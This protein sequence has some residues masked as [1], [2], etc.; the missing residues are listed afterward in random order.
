MRLKLYVAIGVITLVASLAQA[1][2]LLPENNKS[3]TAPLPNL[4]LG[5]TSQPTDSSPAKTTTAPIT[6]R[7]TA[8]AGTAPAVPSTTTP[9]L[10]PE[11]PNIDLAVPP[12]I[13]KTMQQPRSFT[14]EEI[15]SIKAQIPDNLKA[16]IPKEMGSHIPDNYKQIISDQLDDLSDRQ[17]RSQETPFAFKP[18]GIIKTEKLTPVEQ[19]KENYEQEI[20]NRPLNKYEQIARNHQL[21]VERKLARPP[22]ILED[23]KLVK[24]HADKHLTNVIGVETAMA[25]FWGRDDLR[26]IKDALGY[27]AATVPKACQLRQ[28]VRLDTDDKENGLFMDKIPAGERHMI[29]YNGRIRGLEIKS[30]ALCLPP[31]GPLPQKGSIMMQAGNKYAILLSGRGSC[32]PPANKPYY[33][34]VGIQYY[35]NGEVNCLFQ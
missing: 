1:R 21:E 3:S 30:H 33:P 14:P 34:A 27:D 2:V 23:T 8:P 25:Y 9:T 15:A 10:Q 29:R 31:Q 13:L 11:T 5:P 18:G 22:L 4:G 16:L 7:M 17:K 20:K 26:K 6:P 28:T 19:M 24:T 12:E 35:G 32:K